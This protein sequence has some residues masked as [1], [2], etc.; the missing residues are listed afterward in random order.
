[1][2]QA[3][4][5]RGR[6]LLVAGKDGHPFRKRA[7]RGDHGGPALVAV[8]DQVEEQLAADAVEGDEAELVDDR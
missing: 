5:E 6:Q 2:R 1:M 3:V 8:R 7:V 4:E